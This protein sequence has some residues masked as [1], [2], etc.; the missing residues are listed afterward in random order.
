MLAMVLGQAAMALTLHRDQLLAWTAAAVV[1]AAITFL[2]GEVNLRVEGA[3]A[4]SSV[5]AA[6]ALGLVVF[7]RARRLREGGAAAGGRVAAV[8]HAGGTP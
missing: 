1:L 8:L 4:L 7:L 3:Y 6:L 5:T 2:P